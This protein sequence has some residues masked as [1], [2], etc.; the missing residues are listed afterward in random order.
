MSEEFFDAQIRK[1]QGLDPIRESKKRNSVVDSDDEPTPKRS[2]SNS[3]KPGMWCS[4]H[5]LQHMGTEFNIFRYI[6][7]FF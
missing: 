4:E 1:N 6:V 7:S 3:D 5:W 2:K